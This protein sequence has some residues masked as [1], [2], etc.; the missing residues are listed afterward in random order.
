MQINS[1]AVLVNINTIFKVEA[2]VILLFLVVHRSTI[3][4]LEC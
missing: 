4:F 3:Y 2:R 1:L